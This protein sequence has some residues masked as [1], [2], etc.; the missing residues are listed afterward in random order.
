MPALAPC[1]VD[2]LLYLA[3]GL[4]DGIAGECQ[5]VGYG[6][7]FGIVQPARDVGRDHADHVVVPFLAAQGGPGGFIAVNP[8]ALRAGPQAGSFRVPL[9]LGTKGAR[10]VCGGDEGLFGVAVPA[11]DFL[12]VSALA[13]DLA[14]PCVRRANAHDARGVDDLPVGRQHVRD[15]ALDGCPER[16]VALRFFQLPE[17]MHALVRDRAGDGHAAPWRPGPLF[18]VRHRRFAVRVRPMEKRGDDVAVRCR[19]AARAHGVDHDVG[20]AAP[21]LG[22]IER[23]LR[24][25]CNAFRGWPEAVVQRRY[26]FADCPDLDLR[27]FAQFRPSAG[28]EPELLHDV[29]NIA[30]RVRAGHHPTCPMSAAFASSVPHLRAWTWSSPPRASTIR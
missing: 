23:I 11:P 3:P 13:L 6:V 19:V 12:D 5:P 26:V 21:V 22:H 24:S 28:Q 17:H 30:L 8:T 14:R 18:Q 2:R 10:H 20:V 29:R 27:R 9:R 1:P 25:V 15:A 16:H 4:I 7:Y